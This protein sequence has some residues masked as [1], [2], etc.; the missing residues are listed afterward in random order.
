M[1]ENPYSIYDAV[2]AKPS[3]SQLRQVAIRP[4]DLFQRGYQ[5]IKDQYWLFL[6]IVLVAMLIGSAVPFGILMG[7]MMVG[8]HMAL[9]QRWREGKTEFGTLFKGFDKF[10][11]GLIAMLIMFAASMIVMIP[12]VVISLL[13]FGVVVA[14]SQGNEAQLG[15]GLLMVGV[16]YVGA[17]I[18]ATIV[19]YLPFLFSFQLIA[20]QGLSGFD[21]CKTSFRGVMANLWGL[22]WYSFI[23]AVTGFVLTLMCY[24]PAILFMPVSFA[25]LFVLYQDIFGQAA[26]MNHL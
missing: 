16:L 11:D 15:I 25:S 24:I 8:V 14:S 6:G 12:V 2:P 10:G 21:A 20:D 18:F 9:G 22:I 26:K 17:I 4:F 23:L 5:L 13:L 7:P 19:C 1:K 3:A